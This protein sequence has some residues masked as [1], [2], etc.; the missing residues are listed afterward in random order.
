[1]DEVYNMRFKCTA[2]FAVLLAL[3][4][5]KPY[6]A[7]EWSEKHVIVMDAGS[8]GSRVYIYK[9]EENFPLETIVE[10]AHMRVIPAL[11]TFVRNSAGLTAQ[12]DKLVEFAMTI[13][14]SSSWSS[15]S[16]CLKATAGLR[17]LN[18]E[19]QNYLIS[20]TAAALEKS[21]FLFDK[22]KTK[23]ITGAEEALFDIL[24]VTA[25]FQTY[26]EGFITLG[27]A[28]MGGSSQQ[29]AFLYSSN[30]SNAKPE[31]K[32]DS[33]YRDPRK[34]VDV[35]VDQNG[36]SS[37]AKMSERCRPD[38]RIG[39]P[40]TTE[41]VEIFSKSFE[42]MGIIGAMDTALNEFYANK[43][44]PEDCLTSSAS[45]GD[46]DLDSENSAL[47]HSDSISH[48]VEIA[49]K[50]SCILPLHPCLPDG[51]FPDVPGFIGYPQPLHGKGNFDKCHQ[52]LKGV[53]VPQ[54]ERVVDLDCI[55]RHRP[56]VM[57]GMD[58]YPK[59]LEVLGIPQSISVAPSTI[60]QLARAVCRRPW[61]ELLAE[62]PDFMPYR[63]QRACFGATYVYTMLVDIY[64]IEEDDKE[65]F[66]PVD[67]VGEH[68]LSWALGSAVFSAMNLEVY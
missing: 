60:R 14:P 12:I 2:L 56:K 51:P 67:S 18:E 1:V 64:G 37:V 17:S 29:I 31:P 33:Y 54:A 30:A 47:N 22:S 49:A 42:D 48:N 39:I 16:I 20:A 28:D 66:L 58:N 50:P 35:I 46:L 68:E 8:T 25:L 6:L 53:L 62:Y 4:T 9:Y 21:V 13:A 23:V 11:S 41:I 38:W 44:T 10:V 34:S 45:S 63:A 19:D 65:A 24:A 5:G 7:S 59:A 61:K 3:F 36:E 26:K 52:L 55:K 32:L 43:T 27:A 15:T 40:G 57:V